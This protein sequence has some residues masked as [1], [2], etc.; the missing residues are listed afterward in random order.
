MGFII[1]EWINNVIVSDF[2]SLKD[3]YKLLYYYFYDSDFN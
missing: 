3:N 1:I 2:F